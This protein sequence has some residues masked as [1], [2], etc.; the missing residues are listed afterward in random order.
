MIGLT[1]PGE[2]SHLRLNLGGDITEFC[3]K[4]GTGERFSQPDGIEGIAVKTN[5]QTI[6]CGSRQTIKISAVKYCASQCAMRECFGWT[7]RCIVGDILS[8]RRLDSD[9]YQL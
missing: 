6:I 5:L 7:H 3:S 9:R 1:D 2:A 4:I 8:S